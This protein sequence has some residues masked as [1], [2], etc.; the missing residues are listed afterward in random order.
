[1]PNLLSTPRGRLLAFFLLYVSEGIP[2]GFA[3]KAVVY[4][5]R[6]LG[7]SPAAVGAF[8]ATLYLPWAWKWVAGPFVDA[9]YS[10]RLGRRRAWI[11]GCQ[12]MMAVTL[13]AAMPIDFVSR[14]QLFTW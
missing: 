8:V 4:Q 10:P 2:F 7:L 14:V 11:F 12:V 3:S 13:L 9:F 6:S 5:M 1:M